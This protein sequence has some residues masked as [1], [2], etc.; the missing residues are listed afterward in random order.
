MILVELS[1]F[2]F[3]AKLVN[4]FVSFLCHI[5][6]EV[7]RHKREHVLY[8]ETH[9]SQKLLCNYVNELLAIHTEHLYR[10][11]HHRCYHVVAAYSGSNCVVLH[12]KPAAFCTPAVVKVFPLVPKVLLSNVLKNS[13]PSSQ[14]TYPLQRSYIVFIEI[15]NIAP[16]HT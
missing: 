1:S 15:L 9:M 3:Q 10:I 6:F 16:S 2:R 11:G 7:C 5:C 14:K 13:V 8:M 12:A 4:C